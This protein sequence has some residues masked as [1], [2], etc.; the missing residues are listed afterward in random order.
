MILGTD[1]NAYMRVN[2][3]HPG[4]LFQHGRLDGD[5]EYPG[6]SVSE[7]AAKLG[8]D[9]GALSR[10]VEGRAPFTIDLA[11]KMEALG[12]STADSWL[13]HQLDYNLAQAPA[14]LRRKQLLAE[15]EAEETE[16]KAAA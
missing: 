7:A 5:D 15:A 6:M 11:L 10:V 1:E 8:V 3:L 13:K 2:P 9:S 4:R 12:W 16:Q 14:V